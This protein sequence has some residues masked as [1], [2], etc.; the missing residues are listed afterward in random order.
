[1][2]IIFRGY[3][4]LVILALLSFCA[5]ADEKGKD[6]QWFEM[7]RVGFHHHGSFE[8]IV[9]K[10]S[11]IAKYFV[12]E[13]PFISEAYRQKVLAGLIA[14]TDEAKFNL[15]KHRPPRDSRC[16]AEVAKFN[17]KEV[18]IKILKPLGG[19][20]WHHHF[21]CLVEYR[22]KRNQ[23]ID[24]IFGIDKLYDKFS[25]TYQGIGHGMAGP[26]D[27]KAE[28]NMVA[29]ILGKP[30]Y[31]YPSQSPSFGRFY[32]RKKD[33]HVE[34]HH[35]QIYYLERGIP[36]WVKHLKKKGKKREALG[37]TLYSEGRESK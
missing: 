23:K 11:D 31:V 8:T 3:T 33:L 16:F 12:R 20:R 10:D 14:K 24:D 4:T 30:D 17:E 6:T 9:L 28:N 35:F 27:I 37:E 1:M 21:D 5:N 19:W 2:R 32:Y 29:G 25:F 18:Y 13:E 15:K 26:D 36:E 34:T 22:I 7:N